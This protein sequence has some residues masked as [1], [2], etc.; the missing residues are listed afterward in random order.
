M[1][2]Y[3]LDASCNIKLNFDSGQF[4]IGTPVLGNLDEDDELEIVFGG[5]SNPGKLFAINPD[6]SAV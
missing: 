5:Y 3:V 2:L 4:L 6:G 1:H